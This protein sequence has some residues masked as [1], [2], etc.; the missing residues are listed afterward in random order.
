MAFTEMTDD[1]DIIAKY[2][3]E[4]YEEEGF[5]STA[6]KA[7]FDQ[8]AK[9][10]KAALNALVRALNASTAAASVGFRRSA[11]IPENYV[12]DAIENVQAQIAGVTQGAVPN[13]SI[14]GEKLHD[15]AVTTEKILDGAVTGGKIASGGLFEDASDGVSFECTIGFGPGAPAT[16]GTVEYVRVCPG[17]KMVFFGLTQ[18][19]QIPEN[20]YETVRFELQ[21]FPGLT[22]AT[23]MDVCVT[24]EIPEGVIGEG[25]PATGFDG[26]HVLS[27]GAKIIW[28]EKNDANGDRSVTTQAIGGMFKVT[29][30]YV[31]SDIATAEEE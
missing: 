22:D 26:W 12:Q 6:F 29:G 24:V 10:C 9:L 28:V 30:S 11:N 27:R 25:L 1:L 20:T 5:T 7:S 17:L 15:G 18:L 16:G 14:T 4:P 23:M 3:D 21:D 2:P 8:G 13:G 19:V 31:F